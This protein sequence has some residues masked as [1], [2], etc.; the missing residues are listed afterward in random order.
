MKRYVDFSQHLLN[1]KVCLNK[2]LS[3][4]CTDLVISIES[5]DK[6]LCLPK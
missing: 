2:N 5:V 4:I 3:V 1:K 6:N